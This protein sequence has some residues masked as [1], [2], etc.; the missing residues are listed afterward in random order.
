MS[1]TPHR[2]ATVVL[3]LVLG[4]A[5]AACGGGGSST[6]GGRAPDTTVPT[7]VVIATDPAVPAVVQVGHRLSIVLPAD[8]GGGSRWVLQ[9]FDTS[10]LVALGSEFSDDEAERA[11]SVIVTTTT[12]TTTTTTPPGRATTTAAPDA[13]TTT[14]TALPPLV[15]VVS[16]AGRAEGTTTLTFR[17]NRIVPSPDE[18]PMVVTWRVQVTAAP[19]PT[20]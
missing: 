7:D 20:R 10:R 14:T 5:L 16:F 19:P 4:S 17:S 15:Q 3:V 2:T 1:R 18:R 11:A 8:P 12:A 13:P 9:P 6:N